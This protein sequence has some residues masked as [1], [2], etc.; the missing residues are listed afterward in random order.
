MTKGGHFMS[1]ALA[2]LRLGFL[3]RQIRNG[4][5]EPDL[6]G[7]TDVLKQTDRAL[8]GMSN[9][10]NGYQRDTVVE[11]WKRLYDFH[12]VV[13][14]RLLDRLSET[15][16]KRQQ[17]L[18]SD[19]RALLAAII[20]GE[21]RLAAW[22]D[23]GDSLA[24]VSAQ[25]YEG[26]LAIPL[27][28]QQWD[29]IYLGVNRLSNRERRIVRPFFPAGYNDDLHLACQLIG[30][31]SGL[32]SLLQSVGDDITAIPKW[33]GTIISYRGRQATIKRQDNSVIIPIL[34]EFERLG[35]RE[36][37]SLPSGLEGEVKQAIYNFNKRGI[38]RL[39]QDGSGVRW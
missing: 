32:C 4:Q 23:I 16:K 34:D 19:L 39:S 13:R 30:T 17:E 28:P 37:I 22:F 27:S 12:S 2:A 8:H 38:V 7:V 29:Y 15:L 18:W 10:M 11:L 6:A 24:D 5:K 9:R 14:R 25:L 31:Y 3:S 33:S 35:W 1:E 20:K 26:Q 36:L 21:S